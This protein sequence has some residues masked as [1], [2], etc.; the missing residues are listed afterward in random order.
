MRGS[1]LVVWD[2][3]NSPSMLVLL[4]LV[5]GY[6]CVVLSGSALF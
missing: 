5:R 4:S 6:V 1:A 3:Y 2:I